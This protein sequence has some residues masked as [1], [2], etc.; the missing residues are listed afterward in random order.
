M[1]FKMIPVQFVTYTPESE[2]YTVLEKI[3]NSAERM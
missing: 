2:Y 3:N 1:Y